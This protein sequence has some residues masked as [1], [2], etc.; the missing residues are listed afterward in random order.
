MFISSG[1]R[2]ILWKIIKYAPVH[3]GKA[4]YMYL[5]IKY[6]R[7]CTTRHITNRKFSILVSIYCRIVITHFIIR[8][9]T[10]WYPQLQ[11]TYDDSLSSVKGTWIYFFN[12]IYYCF[13]I[14]WHYE[15]KSELSKYCKHFNYAFTFI[16]IRILNIFLKCLHYSHLFLYIWNL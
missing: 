8:K 1:I 14:N 2:Q 5:Y 13:Y 11:Q 9:K 4:P 6:R 15:K 12:I 7:Q 3:K 10:S 16:N